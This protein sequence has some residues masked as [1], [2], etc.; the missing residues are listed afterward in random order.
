MNELKEPPLSNLISHYYVKPVNFE[1]NPFYYPQYQ[2][3]Y[4]KPYHAPNN[5]PN[6]QGTQF[7]KG[8]AKK[9][10]YKHDEA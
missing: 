2:A 9:P 3:N 5:A 6:T 8:G 7:Q 4:A 1:Q 10:A